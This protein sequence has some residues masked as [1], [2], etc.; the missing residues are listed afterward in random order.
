MYKLATQA[1]VVNQSSVIDDETARIVSE[2]F[3]LIKE[4]GSGESRHSQVPL[5]DKEDPT[6]I[7]SD[8]AEEPIQVVRTWTWEPLAVDAV[9]L[10]LQTTKVCD[11]MMDAFFSYSS[12][13]D[14]GPCL[15][16][17]QNSP[18]PV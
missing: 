5:I 14:N 8:E 13:L 6:D 16:K 4:I 3:A 15:D 10:H 9:M 11:M 17:L 1:D 7:D 18:S 2:G 12:Q